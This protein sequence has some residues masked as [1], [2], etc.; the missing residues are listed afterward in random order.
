MPRLWRD[1]RTAFLLYSCPP[2][3]FFLPYPSYNCFLQLLMFLLYFI[4]AC[5]IGTA[6]SLESLW[7]NCFLPP[8]WTFAVPSLL[9][10][11][12]LLLRTTLSRGEMVWLSVRSCMRTSMLPCERVQAS[13]ASRPF[14]PPTFPPRPRPPEPFSSN[15]FVLTWFV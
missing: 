7:A 10:H 15:W 9:S 5:A 13:R 14:S 4:F 6:V 12:A 11:L 2:S 3:P 1:S 8:L